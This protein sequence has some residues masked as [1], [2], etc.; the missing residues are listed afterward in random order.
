MEQ[1]VKSILTTDFINN[2]STREDSFAVDLSIDVLR[3][4]SEKQ[5]TTIIESFK[6]IYDE[7]KKTLKYKIT[8]DNSTSIDFLSSDRILQ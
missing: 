4:E 3:V 2:Q 7:D 1:I 8:P 5:D 6:P